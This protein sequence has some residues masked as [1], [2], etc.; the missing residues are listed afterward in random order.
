V[1]RSEW[2]GAVLLGAGML[3]VGALAWGLQLRPALEVDARALAELP[4]ELAGWYGSEIPLESAV[5]RELDAQVNV[6]RRYRRRTGE[7]VWLY[8]GYYGTER[9][10]RPEHTP[11][12]CYTGAGWTIDAARTLD[13][14][15]SA[16]AVNEFRVSRDGEEL[17]VHFWYRSHRRS[18][19]LG[20]LD[21]NLDR[22]LGRIL[23]GRADGALVRVSA[24]VSRD[25]ESAVRSQLV[26]FALAVEAELDARWPSE[27]P[28]SAMASLR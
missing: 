6:Q 2:F 21:Q 16:L 1:K 8:I 23:D 13:V 7:I 26:S 22:M 27:S 15:G 4:L 17:L 19:M 18:G 20:G 12:G 9:G 14:G 3:G 25:D 28:R 24:P 5:E 10:G 11:R